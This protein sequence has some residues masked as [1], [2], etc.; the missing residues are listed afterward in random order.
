MRQK[1]QENKCILNFGEISLERERE[2]GRDRK[3]GRESKTGAVR[4]RLCVNIMLPL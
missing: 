1:E 4:Q 3:T 2:E